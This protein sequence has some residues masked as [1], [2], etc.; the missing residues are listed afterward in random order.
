MNGRDGRCAIKKRRRI[1]LRSLRFD[2]SRRHRIRSNVVLA[3]L[4]RNCLREVLLEKED[5]ELE[6]TN[7]TY[8]KYRRTSTPARAAPV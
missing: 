2:D 3:P 5:N 6:D 4:D 1:S 7:A 8:A